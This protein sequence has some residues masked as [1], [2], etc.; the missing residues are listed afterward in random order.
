MSKELQTPEVLISYARYIEHYTRDEQRPEVWADVT[1]FYTDKVKRP[2]AFEVTVHLVYT[3]EDGFEVSHVSPTTRV[4]SILKDGSSGKR[5][6][7]TYLDLAQFN[8]LVKAT[9]QRAAKTYNAKVS[10][11][12]S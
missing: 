9:T 10:E 11:S 5:V 7:A 4:V 6:S 1:D 3:P 12:F 8:E 2:I